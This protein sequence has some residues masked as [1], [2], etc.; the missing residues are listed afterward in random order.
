MV[1]HVLTV[2]FRG[3]EVVPIDVQVQFSPGIPNFTIVG[4]PDKSVGESRE[5]VRAALSALGLA[6]PPKR[7]TVNLSPTDLVKEGNH[8]DLPIA[9]GVLAALGVVAGEV[10]NGY[11][12]LG[13]LSL[14]GALNRVSG[15]LPVA[16][17]AASLGYG[18]VCPAINGGEAAWGGFQAID[19]MAED[20]DAAGRRELRR[21]DVVAAPSLLALINHLRGTQRLAE[22][23]ATIAE[24]AGNYPDLA[25]V[26]GQETAKR[27]L[28]VAAA[29]GHNL[30]MMG[31]PGAGKS[32]LAARL[33]GLLPPLEPSEALDVSMIHSMAGL[34]ETGKLIRRRPFRDPHHTATAAALIG[35]G[36]RVRP[37]EISLA[38]HGVLFL[39]ELPEFNRLALEALRQPL[40][41]GQVVLARANG[42]ISFPSRVQIVAALNPCKCGYA[43]DASRAC[44]RAPRCSL[45]YQGRISGPLYDRMDLFVDVPAV[46]GAD[47]AL[48][49]P[50]ET[51]ADVAAR[52]SGARK[53]QRERFEQLARKSP[54]AALVVRT[55]AQADGQ[56]LAAIATPDAQGRALLD[57]ATERLGLSARGYHRVLRVARTLAD[58]DGADAVS[59]LHIAEALSWRRPV[60]RQALAA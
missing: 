35:G 59:R 43:D 30:V 37:G 4:L 10:A 32:M 13:E 17:H 48:P 8:F 56:V 6:L 40:E 25:E 19:V 29:G 5:R 38:H 27:A 18:I 51:S 1:A 46:S 21:G 60:A 9:L 47:L 2:A 44:S 50:S 20:D 12:V 28:E 14:D 16:A 52:I 41:T 36:T 57:R 3:L 15:V 58:L 26:K 53:I 31:P 22:P 45:E 11:F 7:V 24:D 34:L 33:P 49:P 42:H 55:N 23:S 54:S 39:D